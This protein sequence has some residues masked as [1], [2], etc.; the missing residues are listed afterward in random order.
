ME[1]LVEGLVVSSG[2]YEAET[3]RVVLDHPVDVAEGQRAH[4]RYT[5]AGTGLRILVRPAAIPE[6][7][8]IYG[9]HQSQAPGEG[10]EGQLAEMSVD[11]VMAPQYSETAVATLMGVATDPDPTLLEQFCGA[12]A[13]PESELPAMRRRYAVRAACL[14]RGG[15]RVR[16][17]VSA[18]VE[19]YE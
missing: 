7:V 4:A 12:H 15:R 3:G 19:E 16:L 8:I 14:A 10:D 1:F 11:R 6:R 17:V 9:W 2:T 13:I 5:N 18:C